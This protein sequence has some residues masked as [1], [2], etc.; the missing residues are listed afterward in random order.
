MLINTI[1]TYF[2][3]G[4]ASPGS[5]DFVVES[6]GTKRPSPAGPYIDEGSGGP[7]ATKRR[8]C[9]R[10]SVVSGGVVVNQ[11]ATGQNVGG[12]T[13]ESA[14]GQQ[15]SGSV[16]RGG[17]ILNGPGPVLNPAGALSPS[18]RSASPPQVRV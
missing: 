14:V 6:S 16:V 3:P 18:N 9:D 10:S 15:Q 7:P 13:N 2:F 11:N 1:L 8:H 5:P 17:V 12:P 4:S